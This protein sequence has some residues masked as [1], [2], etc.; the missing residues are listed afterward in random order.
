LYIRHWGEDK[1]PPWLRDK[2][3]ASERE[4]A[5]QKYNKDLKKRFSEAGGYGILHSKFEKF[6]LQPFYKLSTFPFTSKEDN[7]RPPWWPPFSPP[8]Q[9]RPC[10]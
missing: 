7:T 1:L 6:V 3:T 10:E 8:P 5:H 2:R 9:N 4:A